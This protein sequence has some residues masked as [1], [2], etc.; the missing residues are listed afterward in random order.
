MNVCLMHIQNDEEL[1][2]IIEEVH[3]SLQKIKSIDKTYAG[4]HYC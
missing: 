4:R 2:W 1:C 3:F